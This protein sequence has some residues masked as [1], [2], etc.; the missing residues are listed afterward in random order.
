VQ[1]GVRRSE[2]Y[3]GKQRGRMGRRRKGVKR[4]GVYGQQQ[5]MR[6]NKGMVEDKMK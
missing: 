5:Q 6:R 2:K 4:I 3:G 1:E